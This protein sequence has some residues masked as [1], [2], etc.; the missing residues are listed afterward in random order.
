MIYTPGNIGKGN[1]KRTLDSLKECLS[2]VGSLP[3]AVCGVVV[4]P[5]RS[6]SMTGRLSMKLGGTSE[7]LALKVRSLSPSRA[8]VYS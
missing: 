7:R 8:Q 6:H 3:L 5:I 2:S 1:S 4:P